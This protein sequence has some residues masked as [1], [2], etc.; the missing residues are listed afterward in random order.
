M[1]T[2]EETKQVGKMEIKKKNGKIS[3]QHCAGVGCILPY[4]EKTGIT[5]IPLAGNY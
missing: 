3:W 4:A 1:Q 5:G 2:G